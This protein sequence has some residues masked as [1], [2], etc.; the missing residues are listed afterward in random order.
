MSLG[1]LPID[2]MHS[3]TQIVTKLGKLIFKGF[4]YVEG[5]EV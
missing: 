3:Q 4:Q 2:R 5:Q 1:L